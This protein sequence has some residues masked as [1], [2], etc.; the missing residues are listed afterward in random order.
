M[1]FDLEAIERRYCDFLAK[2]NLAKSLAN[3]PLTFTEKILYAH[4][5]QLAPSGLR[6]GKSYL[7]LYPDRVATQDISAQTI[8]L[9]HASIYNQR[10][11]IPATVHCDHLIIAQRGD[12]EDLESSLQENKEVFDFLESASRKYGIGYW[13]PGSGIIHQILLENYTFPGGLLLG[14]EMHIAHAGSLGMLG[15]GVGESD[16]V[17]AMAG[18]TWEMPFP[19][20]IGIKILG[21]LKGWSSAKDVIFHL[22]RELNASGAILEYFGEGI[23]SI[24][25]NGRAAICN[26]GAEL[27]ALSSLFPCD[28]RTFDYL[29]ATGREPVIKLAEGIGEGL[30]PDPEVEERPD[31]YFDQ[32]I[33]LNLSDIEPQV[34]GPFDPKTSWRLTG[35]ADAIHKNNYPDKISAA[36]IGSCTHSSYE[37]FAKVIHLAQQALKHGLKAKCPL[38]IALGSDQIRTTLTY[39]GILKT[40]QEIGAIL[41]PNAC[42]PCVGQ[43]K[44]Q[45]VNFGEKNSI[46][47]SFNKNSAG[48]NDGNPGTHSFLASPEIVMAMA[49]SGTMTFNPLTDILFNQEGLPIKL[50]PPKGREFPT[51]GFIQNISGYVPPA[52]DETAM[53]LIIN[54]NSQ[55]LQLIPPFPAWNIEEFAQLKILAK[56]K[57]K[58]TIDHI[59]PAGKWLRF[60]GH[61]DHLSDNFLAGALNAYQPVAGKGKNV[62]N[63]SVEPFSKIA[64]TYK[65]HHL[66]WVIVGDENF[67]EGAVR[68]LA[69]LE[70]RFL[71][72]AA[73]LAKS[74]SREFELQLKKHGLLALIFAHSGDYDKILVDDSICIEGLHTLAPDIP[75][76]ILLKHAN[77]TQ[78]SLLMYH[79]YT[80]TQIEWFKAGGALNRQASLI[81][82]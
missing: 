22:A 76:T 27:G 48:R 10:T 46:I 73:I 20:R 65:S 54:P 25:V 26:F 61:L 52:E 2:I 64:K 23:K 39:Q 18:L 74:F 41:L 80:P 75:L 55:R 72:G 8:L 7:E 35:L 6:G 47:S 78:E 12:K 45:D 28:D 21:Q 57:D 53:E 82:V 70:A 19:K 63:G 1:A 14:T 40:L 34:N 36:F 9:Q 81:R 51:Q 49:L 59:S 60:R 5:A 38:Y 3:R 11:Q 68:E 69:S 79:T 50:Q 67:G 56:I 16:I 42:G 31:L 66:G 13:R 44:R 24:S 17:E 62:L 37:D 71:G 30:R 4:A 33:T 15:F 43:W 29:R 77:H 58:C 32:V